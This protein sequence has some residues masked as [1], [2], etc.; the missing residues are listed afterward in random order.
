MAATVV[1]GRRFIEWLRQA[2]TQDEE[3]AIKRWG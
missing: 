3:S 1:D 2:I